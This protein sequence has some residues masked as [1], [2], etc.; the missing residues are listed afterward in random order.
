[1]KW[2]RKMSVRNNGSTYTVSAY[3][4]DRIIWSENEIL[5]KYV[6]KYGFTEQQLPQSENE[7]KW[8]SVKL[9]SEV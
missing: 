7:T 5:L 2:E 6:L 8:Y 9:E 4:N 3:V 1:M